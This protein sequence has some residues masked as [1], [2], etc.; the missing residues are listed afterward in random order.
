[1]QRLVGIGTCVRAFK[2]LVGAYT[3]Y[4][5]Q[6]MEL[7]FSLFDSLLFT[8][9]LYAHPFLILRFSLKQN[10]WTL[11]IERGHPREWIPTED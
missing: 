9:L 1:M 6:Y 2:A 7:S 10:V 8:V 5:I 11:V 4:Y 3:P